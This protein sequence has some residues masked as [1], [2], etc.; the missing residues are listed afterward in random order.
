MERA[1][2]LG[3]LLETM[4]LANAARAEG[5]LEQAIELLQQA[6]A[7]DPE[8]PGAAAQLADTRRELA[9]RTFNQAMTSGYPALDDGYFSQWK[10]TQTRYI[11]KT[12]ELFNPIPILKVPML[13]DQVVGVKELAK[14]SEE[15][16]GSVNPEQILYADTPYT[17]R[18]T[19]Q[20]YFLDIKIPFLSKKEVELSKRNEELIIRIGVNPSNF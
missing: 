1:Q 15:V 11:K 17:F 9:K 3:P 10:K 18:K 7:S 5:N 19:K 14:L 6:V 8:H 13:S 20:N 2:N 12:E 4:A 16:Y